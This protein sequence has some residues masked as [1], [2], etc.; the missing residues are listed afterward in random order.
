[1][2]D[3]HLEKLNIPDGIINVPRDMLYAAVNQL[4]CPGLVT[5]R[6]PPIMRRGATV[7][8]RAASERNCARQ[9]HRIKAA[10]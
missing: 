4:S 5:L 2:F 3:I 1:M 10:L 6:S 9:T 8:A 7:C